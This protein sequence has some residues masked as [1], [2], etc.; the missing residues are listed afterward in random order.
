VQGQVATSTSTIT[1]TMCMLKNAKFGAM[2][3]VLVIDSVIQSVTVT[4]GHK[5]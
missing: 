4:V 1:I 2:L 5:K 3:I